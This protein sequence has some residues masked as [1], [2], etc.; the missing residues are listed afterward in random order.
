MERIEYNQFD[1]EK[2]VERLFLQIGE[3]GRHIRYICPIVRGGSVLA[4]ALQGKLKTL[5]S[6]IQLLEVSELNEVCPADTLVVDDIADSGRTLEAFINIGCPIAVI[7]KQEKCPVI[8]DFFA[9]RIQKDTWIDYWWESKN[10]NIE[11]NITRTIS[12]IGENPCREGLKETPMRVVKSWKELYSGYEQDPKDVFKIFEDGAC[13]SMV[14]LKD[15]EFYSTCEHHL[16]P[17]F[18]K[19]H[20]AYIPD[21]KVIGIS[22]LARLL[23]VYSRRMQIQERIGE[24]VTG[25][26]MK[27]L[28]PK[29]AICILEAQ[30]FCMTSRG[31]QKQHSQMVTSSIK[32]DFQNIPVRNEFLNLIK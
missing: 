1:F 28:K 29:G 7:H 23:E 13:D 25:E 30:H 9:E 3:S 17:F 4:V 6:K 11:D 2:D 21:K 20:I 16:L 22:K 31:V 27:H 5:F 19:A 18:G 26:L 32:G 15:I 10:T 24:Q 14:I 8:I 12:F